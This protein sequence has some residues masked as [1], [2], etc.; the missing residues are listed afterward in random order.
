MLVCELLRLFG[1]PIDVGLLKYVWRKAWAPTMN[2]IGVMPAGSRPLRS[3]SLTMVW[4]RAIWPE[5]N[6]T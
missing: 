1:K 6:C 2:C 3:I 4:F 5:G